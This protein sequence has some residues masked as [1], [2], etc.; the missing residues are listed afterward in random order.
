LDTLIYLH[1][2]R[3]GFGAPHLWLGPGSISPLSG[4]GDSYLTHGEKILGA[5]LTGQLQVTRLVG[6][7]S[8]AC[9]PPPLLSSTAW[10][11]GEDGLRGIAARRTGR[12]KSA[13]ILSLN[14]L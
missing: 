10:R 13:S 14:R 4:P 9:F 12:R 8:A 5:I 6:V 7:M 1:G 3:S 11:S 2:F